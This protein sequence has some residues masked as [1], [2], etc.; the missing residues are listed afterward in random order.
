MLSSS[1][2]GIHIEEKSVRSTS[3]K[4]SSSSSNSFSSTDL[5][6][7]FEKDCTGRMPSRCEGLPSYKEVGLVSEAK[8]GQRSLDEIDNITEKIY[9]EIIGWYPNF[10]YLPNGDFCVLKLPFLF[11]FLF[12]FFLAFVFRMKN[13]RSFLIDN[14][15]MVFL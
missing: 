10:F 13:E 15:Y 12:P 2:T 14:L 8:W 9:K 3:S 6:L 11:N 4:S 7:I 1:S 5:H